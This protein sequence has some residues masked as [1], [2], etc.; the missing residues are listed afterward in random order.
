MVCSDDDFGLFTD[1][2]VSGP[3]SSLVWPVDLSILIIWTSKFLVCGVSSEYFHFYCILH[4]N[5]CKQIVL[6]LLGRRILRRPSKVC[7][8]WIYPQNKGLV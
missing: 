7:T 5:G 8:I 3:H 6:T 1:V 2:N 4:R